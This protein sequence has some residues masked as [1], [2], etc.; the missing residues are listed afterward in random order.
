ML[1]DL[2]GGEG[3]RA[4]NVFNL[5]PC[6]RKTFR[7]RMLRQKTRRTLLHHLRDKLVRVK[8]RTGNS[9]E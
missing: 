4:A 1:L 6:A 7:H 5:Q 9:G 8:Q 3:H 2:G